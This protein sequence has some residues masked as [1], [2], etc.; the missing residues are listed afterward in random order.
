MSSHSHCNGYQS[1]LA[2][3]GGA[4]CANGTPPVTA[5]ASVS[6]GS[7]SNQ[8]SLIDTD[9]PRSHLHHHHQQPLPCSDRSDRKLLAPHFFAELN[10]DLASY[11]DAA[12]STMSDAG[13]GGRGGGR[14]RWRRLRMRL[15]RFCN[16][17]AFV[18]WSV[19]RL[20]RKY[21]FRLERAML[22]RFL[23]TYVCLLLALTSIDYAFGHRFSY[24]A[25]VYVASASAFLFA[26]VFLHS[27]LMRPEHTSTGCALVLLLVSLIAATAFPV[28]WVSAS[29]VQQ[30]QIF[31]MADGL[32]QVAFAVFAVY[33]LLPGQLL[34]TALYGSV[35][36]LCY[37]ACS[38]VLTRQQLVEPSRA[39]SV[40]RKHITESYWTSLIASSLVLLCANLGGACL[41]RFR[42]SLLRRSFLETKACIANQL[43][44]EDETYKLERLVQSVVPSDLT[45]DMRA[46]CLHGNFGWKVAQ[47]NQTPYM[48]L[49]CASI[50]GLTKFP[51][52][53]PASDAV[54]LM[55]QVFCR[56]D[57]LAYEHQAFR[58]RIQ[59]DEYTAA[60]G[61][62]HECTEHTTLAVRFGQVLLEMIG[63]LSE[64][65]QLPLEA[66]VG[67]NS[68]VAY[69]ALLGKCRLT[70][71]VMGEQVVIARRLL[72]ACP[73]G[74]ILLSKSTYL[75]LADADLRVEP[76][77]LLDR[78]GANGG[79][80][81]KLETV[82]V[83][84][85]QLMSSS[86]SSS[87]QQHHLDDG[88]RTE[89]LRR[90][91]QFANHQC[92]SPFQYIGETKVN[93]AQRMKLTEE[94]LK[95]Q[96]SG[97]MSSGGSSSPLI[98]NGHA[99]SFKGT[100]LT[101]LGSVKTSSTSSGCGG[102]VAASGASTTVLR[103]CRTSMNP[104]TL[105]F[106][107]QA[108][109]NEYHR[110]EDHTFG[111]AML[112]ALF[113]LLISASL[114]AS[115]LPR[116]MLLLLLFM[117]AFTWI[118]MMLMVLLAARLKCLE[119]NIQSSFVI[120][121]VV[122][123]TSVLFVYA[124]SQ[125][126]VFCCR[127]TVG[128]RTTYGPILQDSDNSLELQCPLPDFIYLS[129]TLCLILVAVFASLPSFIKLF[130][131][132]AVS[133]TFGLTVAVTHRP[134]FSLV[135]SDVRGL[136]SLSGLAASAH[137]MSAGPVPTFVW[138]LVCLTA[139]SILI[140]VHSR[141]H[142]FAQR[143]EFQWKSQSAENQH[144]MF[145]VKEASCCL[146]KNLLPQHVALHFTDTTYRNPVDLYAQEYQLLGILWANLPDWQPAPG[147]EA[148]LL[149]QESIRVLN[150]VICELDELIQ[151]ADR[152]QELVK[153]RTVGEN[154]VVAVGMN[155]QLQDNPASKLFHL[156]GLVQLAQLMRRRVAELNATLYEDRIR[157]RVG[158]DLGP[159]FCGVVGGSRPVFDIWG[160]AASI[161]KVLAS[162]AGPGQ[163]LV[164][165]RVHRVA[166]QQFDF[167][168]HSS[169]NVDGLRVR[170]MVLREGRPAT[171]S[172]RNSQVTVNSTGFRQH[173]GSQQHHHHPS[174]RQNSP[175]ESPQEAFSVLQAG[176]SNN[177]YSA[178]C[179]SGSGLKPIPETHTRSVVAAETQTPTLPPPPPPPQLQPQIQPQPHQQKPQRPRRISDTVASRS[180]LSS[181]LMHESAAFQSAARHPPGDTLDQIVT[182]D[183]DEVAT[184]ATD[185][186]A[187][188]SAS[189][190]ASAE[191]PGPVSHRNPLYTDT[192]YD[193]MAESSANIF[194]E[195]AAVKSSAPVPPPPRPPRGS[196]GHSTSMTRSNSDTSGHHQSQPQHQY[197]PP[198]PVAAARA[199]GKS[200]T[201]ASP[202]AEGSQRSTPSARHLDFP[203]YTR[204]SPP[205]LSP[206][207]RLSD[208]SG[209]SRCGAGGLKTSPPSDTAGATL[210]LPPIEAPIST[211]SATSTSAEPSQRSNAA[212]NTGW[213]TTNTCSGSTV[214]PVLFRLAKERSGAFRLAPVAP[215]TTSSSGI[216]GV[217]S[218]GAAVGDSLLSLVSDSIGGCLTSGDEDDNTDGGV[219]GRGGRDGGCDTDLDALRG[220]QSD[221]GEISDVLVSD[222]DEDCTNFF[223]YVPQAYRPSA[224]PSLQTPT[225]ATAANDIGSDSRFRGNC[226]AGEPEAALMRAWP[227]E[228]AAAALSDA[229]PSYCEP[230]VTASYP[231]PGSEPP[232][233]VPAQRR[234]PQ[235]APVGL[236]NFGFLPPTSTT[237]VAIS[238]ED[239]GRVSDGEVLLTPL[240]AGRRLPAP[241]PRQPRQK[242]GEYDNG[243]DT[244]F[245]E[246]GYET[247]AEDDED[248]EEAG[249]SCDVPSSAYETH[250]EAEDVPGLRR[251]FGYNGYS[252]H[253]G[254]FQNGFG[255]LLQPPH[256]ASSLTPNDTTSTPASKKSDYDNMTDESDFP[257]RLRAAG[258]PFAIG[259]GME[260]SFH[261]RIAAE[262]RRISS[263]FRRDFCMPDG[264]DLSEGEV[265]DRLCHR[266]TLAA[267]L[268]PMQPTEQQGKQQ[269]LPV[270]LQRGNSHDRT[271]PSSG[272][273]MFGSLD[274]ASRGQNSTPGQPR[275]RM[276]HQQPLQHQSAVAV[277]GT[278]PDCALRRASSL[279]QLQAAVANASAVA[280]AAATLELG[281]DA[282]AADL[283]ARNGVI[284]G[285]ARGLPQSFQRFVARHGKMR[286]VLPP[287]L[288]R[289]IL[290]GCISSS[291]LATSVEYPSDPSMQYSAYESEYD[292][293]YYEPRKSTVV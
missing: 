12:S 98:G 276:H 114:Q 211:A 156:T 84:P 271:R 72:Q 286:S 30:Q 187:A 207:S 109:E 193:S 180:S 26:A 121:V 94:L 105:K 21:A 17:D 118:G 45:D 20:Y 91:S 54:K 181:F 126:N 48:S 142:E 27:R 159:G 259:S 246:Y 177:I 56:L 198:P 261:E 104:V 254:G 42:D 68:G 152:H 143:Q 217:A 101:R 4:Q 75:E 97:K 167:T 164:S 61:F 274:R 200:R 140:F 139:F 162:A 59:G 95:C 234:L 69:A 240:N 119:F 150:D 264:A 132:V 285:Q 219:S 238:S 256:Q 262:A 163:I 130:L 63:N 81:T 107:T 33:C 37:L 5:A 230:P 185:N 236:P 202:S 212:A 7:G 249:Y 153:V 283:A 154:Y 86:K 10:T 223:Q 124:V 255:R 71:D 196:H 62:P 38:A 73:P 183:E 50:S 122:I 235:V 65:S 83:R 47:V 208:S 237:S 40:A 268:A 206:A 273:S 170:A 293:Y 127:S 111:A 258:L 138:G 289:Y 90:L 144:D 46:D 57:Q 29:T 277:N 134:L 100:E 16:S 137:D 270:P 92:E 229:D 147:T 188:V 14:S 248:E 117:I 205:I 257:Q 28:S 260:D 23:L 184:E 245:D 242:T 166:Q 35:L 157:M 165:E 244:D 247:R 192:E 178:H 171:S 145:L 141:F 148:P 15:C 158:I 189:A 191:M 51:A 155:P 214:P 103:R 195:M 110:Q 231:P 6:L 128:N 175:L 64:C 41:Q 239:L 174:R 85:R 77:P 11:A 87:R 284:N 116:T 82:I 215:P 146:L 203:E 280:A 287:E 88:E 3:G 186:A 224:P 281:A 233:P 58:V 125:A 250:S 34:A 179:G 120:R 194:M 76:G 222:I 39:D 263:V 149:V 232:T 93:Q 266:Q 53:F 52:S 267:L 253:R 243:G 96:P 32:W 136:A 1:L 275:F 161:S 201:S 67:I 216:G 60:I 108:K 252:G 169:H 265:P 89:G 129:G 272:L 19:E 133:T 291:S 13:E 199:S 292:N 22:S 44:L 2:G 209:G 18:D 176:V 213:E 182:S 8:H 151:R 218:G 282:D 204:P 241:R 172:S 43:Q 135:D 78:P 106:S 24:K 115:V 279:D 160:Q 79:V 113:I 31:T 131:L 220:L 173:Q 221:D 102:Q 99:A 112:A 228:A 269:A 197:R 290:P 123:I 251:S 74:R 227:Q 190:T 210:S 70:Y 49:M 80:R 36:S 66:R 225:A 168:E 55:N 226:N 25:A 9:P 278:S 288:Q